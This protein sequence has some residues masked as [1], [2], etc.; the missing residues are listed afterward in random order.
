MSARPAVFLDRDGTIVHD[1]HYLSRPEQLALMSG[2][3]E[4][5]QRMAA[6]GL[7][8]VVITNQSGI[9]RGMLTEADFTVI[10]AT[11]DAMLATHGVT[12]LATYHCPDTPDVPQ[13]E[14]CRK[15]GDGMYRRAAADHDL[16]LSR[17]FYIGDRWRDIAAAV[18]HG[19]TGIL[20][21]TQDTSF[22]D[23]SKAKDDALVATTLGAAADRVLRTFAQ[24]G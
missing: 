10:T 16:D 1:V 12:L 18:T 20:V 24:R 15:P 14:S 21:P 22:T 5:M 4:A 8:L 11:L 9:G 3:T 2:A 7:P 13:A 19:G 6:A 17:S 23:L